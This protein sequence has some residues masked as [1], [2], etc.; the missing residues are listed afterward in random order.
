MTFDLA[1]IL[2]SNREFRQRLATRPIEEKLALLDALRERAL[3]L[4]PAPP[5]PFILHSS[6]FILP[7]ALLCLVP[8]PKQQQLSVRARRGALKSAVRP[9]NRLDFL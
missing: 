8:L 7:S 6:F 5:V 4:R 1:K 2:Q 9:Q 3:T